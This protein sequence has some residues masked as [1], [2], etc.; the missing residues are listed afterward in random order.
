[1]GELAL[2]AES[3]CLERKNRDGIQTDENKEKVGR[4]NSCLKQYKAK[5]IQSKNNTK[6]K[7]AHCYTTG[8]D[9]RVKHNNTSSVR[10]TKHNRHIIA[11]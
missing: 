3:L 10:D 1:V 4:T 2:R 11:H 6:Q 9:Q 7:Q 8:A 5:T